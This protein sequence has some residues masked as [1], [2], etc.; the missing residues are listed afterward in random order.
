MQNDVLAL[1]N[2]RP[3]FAYLQ[4]KLAEGYVIKFIN[5]D[6][7]RQ[8]LA[9]LDF[10]FCEFHDCNLTQTRMTLLKG[11]KFFSCNLTQARFGHADMRKVSLM[12]CRVDNIELTGSDVPL[13]CYF[14][15]GMK[16]STNTDMFKL[17]YLISAMETPFTAT[18]KAF[19]ESNIPAEDRKLL[20]RA[21]RV[22]PR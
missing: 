7:S 5:C 6:L 22:D 8:N 11:A 21:F 13:D 18:L 1:K 3:D 4:N 9:G 12:N 16:S 20:D 19:M 14:Y 17:L 15:S 10:S 2:F